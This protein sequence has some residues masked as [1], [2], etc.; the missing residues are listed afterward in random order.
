MWVPACSIKDVLILFQ[1]VLHVN[2][3]FFVDELSGLFKMVELRA[4]Y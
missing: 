1:S 3:S 2:G 4:A